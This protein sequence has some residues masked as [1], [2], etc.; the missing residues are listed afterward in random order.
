MTYL[1]YALALVGAAGV[2]SMVAAGVWAFR[3]RRKTWSERLAM[4]RAADA[5]GDGLTA[6]RASR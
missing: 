3:Q 5:W 1:I 6:R 2:G 4:R